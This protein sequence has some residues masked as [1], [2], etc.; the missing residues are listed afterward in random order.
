MLALP[1]AHRDNVRAHR[2]RKVATCWRITQTVPEGAQTFRFTD[3]PENL[4]F[5]ETGV[6]GV[7]ETYLSAGVFNASARR[8][9]AE[10]G[11]NVEGQGVL[12]TET[13]THEELTSRRF[14]NAE[15]A[16]YLV[17][18]DTAWHSSF[19][20]DV[21]IIDGIVYDGQVY[22]VQCSG[23]SRLIGESAG[24]NYGPMC[25]V[26]VFSQGPNKCNKDP[27][28][29]TW[30]SEIGEIYEDRLYFQGVDLPAVS[31]FLNDGKLLW[32]SGKNIGIY[33]DVKVGVEIT[34]AGHQDIL[35]HLKT[36][37]PMTLG[38]EFTVTA[39]CN[40]LAGIGLSASTGHCLHR[41]GNVI[42][43]QGEP[44]IPGRDSV[45]RGARFV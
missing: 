17:F 18:V 43:F 34:P 37:L 24:E 1:R 9:D 42:N 38:D 36:P 7:T 20:F 16:E 33:S 19:S 5:A 6:P 13:L 29:F 28:S 27:T 21:Y 14:D 11:L 23:L 41:Y 35:L 12:L 32:T 8:R 44:T 25:R 3:W 2:T 22:R 40:K 31:G 45:I 39:G 4:E 10:D 30:E 15:V 26:E